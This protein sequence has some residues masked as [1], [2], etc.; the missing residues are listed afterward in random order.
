MVPPLRKVDEYTWEIPKNYKPCMRVNARIYADE[1][2]L[3]KMK[4]DQ[5][6]EQIS[7]VACLPGIYKYSIALP[8]AH[9]GYGF[10]VGGVAAV[11]HEEGAV[12][13]GGIGYDIN[14]LPPGTR[15][16]TPLGYTVRIEELSK[17][18]EVVSIGHG[19]K[20][21]RSSSVRI[22]LWREERRLIRIRTRS[23]F[24]LKASSDHPIM[25]RRG[26]VNAQDVNTHD[27]VAL[28]PFE[29]VPYEDP[30]EWI[31]LTGT[32]FDE[33][34]ASELRM[35]GLLPLSTRNPKLPYLVK[36]LGYLIGNGYIA[37]KVVLYGSRSN[38]EELMRDVERLGF[39]S[40]IRSRI[41]R[42]RPGIRHEY[43]LHISSRGLRELLIALGA[44]NGHT[45]PRVP[46]WLLNMPLWMKRLFLASYLGAR[47]RWLGMPIGRIEGLY[48]DKP[49]WFKRS[50]VFL[51]ELSE[52]LRE[53]GVATRIVWSKGSLRLHVD[54]SPDNLVRLWSRVNYEYNP[55]KRR[56]ALASVVWLRRISAANRGT[57]GMLVEL[58]VNNGGIAGALIST[59]KS[60]YVPYDVSFVD[61]IKGHLDG[62]VVW[63]EVVEVSEEP[64]A[65]L[66][67]DI[68]VDD[69]SHDFVAESFVVSNCGVRLIRTELTV[70]EVR[71][72]LKE[73]VDTI[74]QLVPAGVGETGHLKLQIPELNKVLEEGV[75]W[76]IS[77]GYAWADDK[78]FIE[79]NG[80]WVG[81]DSSKVSQRAKERGRGEIGTIGSG[82]HFT[83]VQFIQRIFDKNVAKALGIDNEGG[84]TI[85]I[86]TGSRGLG[87]QV[88]TDYIRLATEKMRQW[89]LYL[90]DR[91]LA[92]IPLKNKEA[93]DYL[94]AM[95][96]AANYAWTNRQLI[97]H[98]VREAF[99]RVFNRDPDKLGM[100]IVYDLAHNIAKVEEHVID[101]GRIRRVVVHRKGAT[102]AFPAGRE[103]IPRRY[104]DVGQPVLIP[105]S[106]GTGSYVLVGV[107]TSFQVTFGT[108]PHGAGRVL[109]RAAAVR[110]LPPNKVRAEMESKGIIV[111]SAE[112][113]II[114]EEAPQAY[115][116]VDRVAL[117]AEAVGM[118]KRVVR[119]SPL[120]VVKG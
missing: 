14:C 70:D 53:F 21:L 115:K 97:T 35:R 73:L 22:F 27:L 81:A 6:L 33:A 72:K 52:L 77:R 105:G 89:G 61:W 38:L 5:T 60:G 56:L 88:A 57:A 106:M 103:E 49:R 15:V 17:G 43:A 9:Q 12:S 54:P 68:T 91:E 62:D 16:L 18:G 7:N 71:P 20:D 110:M 112:S 120:G 46:S 95:R 78:E 69:E 111:R 102:R 8:D 13:P 98:W 84:V 37:D 39:E 26:M 1:V 109:S 65:G 67:Y 107:P 58:V 113:E 80:H 11:D 99:R 44:P 23:G 87:H 76:A 30:K 96:A 63:D 24:E 90:P 3:E 42:G 34:A 74:F 4:S 66:V 10:P 48:I 19:N 116:D 55:H 2:L 45:S 86:H 101:E 51:R 32:E 82:N 47:M 119:L 108:A 59:S 92:A 40:S 41:R 94:A 36:I 118:A 85:M 25:T 104:R 29:G 117:V 93:E 50:E 75:D 83:E 79:E 114:S 31:L 28:Y 64:Y 100:S